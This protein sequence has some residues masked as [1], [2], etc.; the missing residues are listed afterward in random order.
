[1]LCTDFRAQVEEIAGF[2]TNP[3]IRINNQYDQ[4]PHKHQT[5]I[6][7]G[8]TPRLAWFVGSSV[9]VASP[10]PGCSFKHR[11]WLEATGDRKKGVPYINAGGGGHT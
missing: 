5:H 4:Q 8:G 10:V 11:S 7:N 9:L 3:S 6:P 1:M 2:H